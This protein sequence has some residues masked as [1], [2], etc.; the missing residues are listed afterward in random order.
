MV[1]KEKCVCSGRDSDACFV[2]FWRRSKHAP[3]L[4]PRLSVNVQLT[5]EEIA[6]GERTTDAQ[7]FAG[8]KVTH[9]VST[10]SAT[11]SQSNY[12]SA[13]TGGH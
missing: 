3:R 9:S 1:L 6:V 5:F 13:H 11:V 8:H 12:A 7:R 10:L 4:P 2:A